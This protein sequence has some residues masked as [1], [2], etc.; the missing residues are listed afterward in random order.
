MPATY[1]VFTRAGVAQWQSVGFPSRRSRVRCPSPA[2]TYKNVGNKS[3]YPVPTIGAFRRN[4]DLI[5]PREEAR[6]LEPRRRPLA[7]EA[8]GRASRQKAT[9]HVRRRQ[10]ATDNTVKSRD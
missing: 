8:K 5:Y 6:I 4:L 10:E 1:H 9:D 2:Y 3:A 7:C